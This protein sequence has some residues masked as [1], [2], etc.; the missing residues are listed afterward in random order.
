MSKIVWSII[1]CVFLLT[2]CVEK[3][4]TLEKGYLVN[5]TK[6]FKDTFDIR[7]KIIPL[8][9]GDWRIAGSGLN[10]EKFFVVFLFQE[11]PGKLFSYIHI[12][13]DSLDLIREYGYKPSEDIKRNDMHHTVLVGNTNG[14]AQDWWLVNNVVVNFNPKDNKLALN[15]AAA[16]IKSHNYIISHDM[17]KVE[18]FLSGKH[19]NKKRHL[20]V[21]YVYNPEAVGFPPGQKSEWKTSDWNA[22]RI[23]ED[24]RKT[25]FI[26]ELIEKHTVMHEK[27]KAG[28]HPN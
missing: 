2:G 10:A 21:S 16:Y 13:V 15:E 14:E 24:P 17:I 9:P 4:S 7:G 19:P 8:P 18:H 5:D 25:A 11:H 6:V 3:T 23:N 22:M 28:F 26:K 20:S 27:I 1:F 12:S